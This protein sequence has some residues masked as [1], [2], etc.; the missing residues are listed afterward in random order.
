MR[1]AKNEIEAKG[2]R[3]IIVGNGQPFH[4][5]GFAEKY[6]LQG[7]VFTDPERSVYE[8]AGMTRRVGST[9]SLNTLRSGARALSGGY[10]QGKTQGDPWQQGG[11]L[12]LRPGEGLVYEYIS[13][14]AGDHAPIDAV[15]AAI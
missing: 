8:A 3:L 9:F 12:V 2:A 14:S 11:T 15:L 6:E 13:E 4:A 5:K 1:D 10:R 7:A